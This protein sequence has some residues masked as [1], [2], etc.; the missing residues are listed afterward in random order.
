MIAAVHLDP[1]L[2]GPIAILI[3]GYLVWYW[4]RLGRAD[5]PPGRRRLRRISMAVMLIALP[6]FVAGLSYLDP[7]LDPTMYVVS[8]SVSILLMIVIFFT[9]CADWLLTMHL[10]RQAYLAD[11]MRDR[12]R[13]TPPAD[14]PEAGTGGASPGGSK[15]GSKAA[16]ESA[17]T[18]GDFP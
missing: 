16:S 10:H 2:T 9:A 4:I 13:R 18:G 8:W 6:N 12:A 3:A 17:S 14:D 5:V 1:R 15:P 7:R 11:V